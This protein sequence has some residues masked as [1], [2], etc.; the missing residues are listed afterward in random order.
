MREK[1]IPLTVDEHREFGLELKLVRNTIGEVATRYP[2]KSKV[3]KSAIAALVALGDLRRAMENEMSDLVP[4]YYEF[5]NIY[6]GP[7]PPSS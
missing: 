6:F 4:D 2:G 5:I 3:A 7:I 1:K